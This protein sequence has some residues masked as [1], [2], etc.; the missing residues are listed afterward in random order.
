M[1]FRDN[2]YLKDELERKISA[3]PKY[4]CPLRAFARDLKIAPQILSN[5]LNGKKAISVDV[6]GALAE[7]LEMNPREA[8]HFIDLVLYAHTK[9]AST[10]KHRI[11]V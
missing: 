8:S 5:L 4:S 11:S 7:R 9:N 2:S 10:K 3:N 1:G 6:A